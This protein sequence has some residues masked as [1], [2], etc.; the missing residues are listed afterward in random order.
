MIDGGYVNEP[1]V[2]NESITIGPRRW[3]GLLPGKLAIERT[4]VPIP[5]GM[6]VSEGRTAP[7]NASQSKPLHVQLTKAELNTIVLALKFGR[8][9]YGMLLQLAE[10]GGTTVL[11]WDAIGDLKDLLEG[12]VSERAD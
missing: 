3:F 7:E 12:T 5:S 10:H 1:C 2:W 9:R 8:V 6:T 4:P 11:S